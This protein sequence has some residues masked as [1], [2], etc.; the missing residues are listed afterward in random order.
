MGKEQPKSFYDALYVSGGAGKSYHKHY[1]DCN[2]YTAWLRVVDRLKALAPAK[3]LELGC[4][5][6]QFAQMV[7][8]SLDPAPDYVGLDFSDTA[9][10]MARKNCPQASFRVCDLLAEPPDGRGCD[11][12]VCLEVLEHVH[13]DLS[14]LGGLPAGLPILFSV[15]SY[16]SAGHVRHF[17]D[18]D[19]VRARYGRAVSLEAIVRV[20]VDEAGN[21]LFIAFGTSRGEVLPAESG[22]DA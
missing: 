5:P 9:I 6:G 2:Y 10:A 20:P 21:L 15:P 19:E 4:G 11:C 22:E 8:E 1:S 16:D 17:A 18:E 3:V 13:E 14:I 7:C 12:V